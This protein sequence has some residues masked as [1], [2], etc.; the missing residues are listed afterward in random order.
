MSDEQV[1]EPLL[2]LYRKPVGTTNSIDE[3]AISRLPQLRDADIFDVDQ[4]VDV[5]VFEILLL[6][7][8]ELIGRHVVGRYLSTI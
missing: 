5:F 2:D 4:V 7:A 1:K 8:A 3:G 6:I